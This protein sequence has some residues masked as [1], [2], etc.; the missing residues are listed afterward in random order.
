M[1]AK[2]DISKM[3]VSDLNKM[4][5]D[6]LREQ[7]NLRLQKSMGLLEGKNHMFRQIRRNIARIMTKLTEINGGQ[8]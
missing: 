3:N 4:L 5:L 8:K 1:N 7:S 2:L 6:L